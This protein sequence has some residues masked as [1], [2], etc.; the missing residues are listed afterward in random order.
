MSVHTRH[1]RHESTR[2]GNLHR[3]WWYAIGEV[4]LIFAGITLA[5]WF[6]NW[7]EAERERV[8][9]RHTLMDIMANLRANEAHIEENIEF[10][11]TGVQ[12][13][14]TILAAME[15]RGPWMDDYEVTLNTCRWW[16]S[17]FLSAAAYDSLKLR[18]T[19]LITDRG[20]RD[21]IV[22]LYE[23]NYAYLIDD[24]D[25]SFWQFQEAVLFPVFNRHIRDIGD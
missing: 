18:G 19:D 15:A 16:S 14:N 7:N 25:K 8:V 13:C 21:D 10:D 24:T 6:S 20:L 11:Q 3:Y 5:L 22:K 23:F 17:P 12:A 1:Q 9:E 4:V 2:L